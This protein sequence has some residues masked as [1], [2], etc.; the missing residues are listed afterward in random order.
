MKKINLLATLTLLLSSFS[1]SA[2]LVSIGPYLIDDT[3]VANS[4]TSP[5][6]LNGSDGLSSITDL[7]LSTY[8]YGQSETDGSSRSGSINLGFNNLYNGNAEDLVFYFIRGTGDALTATFDVSIGETTSS[9]D[10]TLA[11]FVDGEG[12]TQKYQV[13][14]GGGFADLLIATVDLNDFNIASGGFIN[15]LDISGIN[16]NERLA[17]TAGLYTTPVPLPAAFFLFLSGIAG[18]GLFGRRKK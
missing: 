15:G 16:N 4:T 17:L 3:A 18:L 14:V 7:S 13:E 8:I 5:I 6:N 2:A 1:A 9:Y 12:L 10:A 11:T